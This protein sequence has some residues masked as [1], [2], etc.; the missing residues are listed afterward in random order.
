MRAGAST[1]LDTGAATGPGTGAAPA[2]TAAAAATEAAQAALRTVRGRLGWI[3]CATGALLCALGWYG[4]SGERYSA[5]QIPYLASATAPGVALLISGAILLAARRNDPDCPCDRAPDHD[6]DTDTDNTHHTTS[7][8][9]QELARLTDQLTLLNQL[10]T[11]ASQGGPES[12]DPRPSAAFR[13]LAVPGGRTY[14]RADCLLVQGRRD[15]ERVVDG[16]AAARG[17]RPCP[18]CE[19]PEA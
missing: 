12:P 1:G 18:L 10:L 3:C 5:R 16:I 14:H 11:E 8:T 17:L 6:T 13:L 7:T 4:V 9:E 15:P 2:A 19:P